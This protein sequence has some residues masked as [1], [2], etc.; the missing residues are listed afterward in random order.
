MVDEGVAKL[1]H[2]ELGEL[3]GPVKTAAR[4]FGVDGAERGK[5]I[6]DF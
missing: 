4:L 5:D 3:F 2:G 6:V 1:V